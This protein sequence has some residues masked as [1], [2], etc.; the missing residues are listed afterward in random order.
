[1]TAGDQARH[2]RGLAGTPG[3]PPGI[4][5]TRTRSSRAHR[6]RMA[7]RPYPPRRITRQR[8]ASHAVGQ[9]HPR[10]G[11]FTEK[12]ELDMATGPTDVMGA[13]E[14][15][16]PARRPLPSPMAILD[17]HPF[18]ISTSARARASKRKPVHRT[19]AGQGDEPGAWEHARPRR[20]RQGYA[21]T[22]ATAVSGAGIADQKRMHATRT[23]Q[24][25]GVRSRT[26]ISPG[27]PVPG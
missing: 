22:N 1:M 18:A 13:F 23:Y 10:R 16:R 9:C 15:M 14:R 7:A 6:Y 20:A 5:Q 3:C 25:P 11:V 8:G 27:R 4:P 2:T 24:W 26:E 19:C 17:S 21:T 12:Q